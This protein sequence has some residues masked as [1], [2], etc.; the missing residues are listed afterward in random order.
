MITLVIVN[1][2]YNFNNL[3]FHCLVHLVLTYGINGVIVFVEGKKGV[4]DMTL[5]TDI[6]FLRLRANMTQRQ[7]AE[8]ADL[9][10]AAVSRLENGHSQPTLDTYLK[11]VQALDYDLVLQ[12]KKKK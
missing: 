10:I 5:I 4:K 8:K 6:R 11:I 12:P 2:K 9:T 1:V 7:V 3:N